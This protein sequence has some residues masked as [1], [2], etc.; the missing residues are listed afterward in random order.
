MTISPKIEPPEER[1]EY[2]VS[3][4]T[5]DRGFFVQDAYEPGRK[6]IRLV[7]GAN[8]SRPV[9][10][11]YTDGEARKWMDDRDPRPLN[12]TMVARV[13]HAADCALAFGQGEYKRARSD[14]AEVCQDRE[15]MANW[16]R[17]PPPE[18]IRMKLWKA[19]KEALQDYVKDGD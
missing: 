14:W 9:D 1:R 16:I 18:P 12:S 5:G 17:L 4:E 7:R 13:C 11:E 10:I 2:V 15:R 19:I 8:T 6:Y 3:T